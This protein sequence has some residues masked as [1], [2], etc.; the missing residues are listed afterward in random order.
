M[1]PQVSK[2]WTKRFFDRNPKFYKKKQKP[3]TVKRKNAHNKDNF[4]KYFEKYKDICIDKGI[5]DNN[6]WNINET[7]FRA[8]FGKAH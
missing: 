5:T 3:L 8:G 4:Q 1:P 2:N 6:V 7:E